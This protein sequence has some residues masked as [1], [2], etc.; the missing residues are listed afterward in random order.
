MYPSTLDQLA[1]GVRVTCVAFSTRLDSSKVQVLSMSSMIH[2]VPR[3]LCMSIT[4]KLM[5]NVLQF[6]ASILHGT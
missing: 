1:Q 5:L 6:V 4:M 2:Y 3:L